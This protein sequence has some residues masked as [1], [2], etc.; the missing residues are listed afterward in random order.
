MVE[1]VGCFLHDAWKDQ[2]LFELKSVLKA[3]K[4]PV[5]GP[6]SC[7]DAG[8]FEGFFLDQIRDHTPWL[9]S[10][11]EPNEQAVLRCREKGHRVWFGH[12]ESALE[13]IPE[14]TRFDVI[15]MSQSIEHM[16]DPVH[17]LR[18]LRLLLAPGGALAV[19]TPNLDS[20]EIDWFGPTWAHWHPPYHRYI[21]SRKGLL[22]LA[23]QAGLKPVCLKTFSHCYW[24]SMSIAQNQFGLGGSVSHAVHFERGI[25]IRAMR[26]NFW[27]QVIWNRLGKGDYSFLVMRDDSDD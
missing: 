18:R 8:C 21:F 15:F 26:S 23:R 4:V 3:A 27:H 1:I 2:T 5:D 22:A 6:I 12:A 9:G 11:L 17:V 7:L 13:I 19:S 24:S 16:D 10:G 14:N 25:A 20:R